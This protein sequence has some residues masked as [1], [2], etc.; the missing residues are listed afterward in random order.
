M[1]KRVTRFASVLAMIALTVTVAQSVQATTISE[2]QQQK[3]ANEA[4]LKD[5]N[6]QIAD[7][8]GAQADIGTEIE[9]LDAEMVGLLTD[10]NLIQEAIKTKEE[11]IVVTQADYDAAVIVKD[12]QYESMKIRI[13]F[14]YEEGETSYIQ[15]FTESLN[16]GDMINK[17]EYIE[18]L[19]AYDRKLLE[20]YQ[21]TVEQVALLQ[22]TLEEEKSEL[23]TSQYELEEEQA[24]LAEVLAEKQKEY[25]DYDI[26]LARA[27]QE[28]AAYTTKIKQETAQIKK[29]EEEEARRRAEEEARRKAEEEARLLAQAQ[30]ES[31]NNGTGTSQSGQNA[32]TQTKPVA[33][34]TGS[35]KGQEIANFACQYVGYPYKAGGTSLTEGADCSGFVWAVYKSFGYSLPRSSYAQSSAGTS[36]SY[37]DAQPG[38]IIYY[39]GHVGIY[40]GNGKIVHASTERTGIKTESATYRSIITVRRII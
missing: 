9:E 14:M 11:E 38:D 10:I 28:A 27:K 24:Y 30:A 33:A 17:A 34:S 31:A 25:E 22:E 12:E 8:K 13:Q 36:V 7:Y 18:Q 35:A 39:G 15:L 16:M 20:E 4:Q 21:A 19:Y 26:M 5:V 37:A 6:Q 2:I 1:K 23:Q 32:S 3:A 40:I 29:L